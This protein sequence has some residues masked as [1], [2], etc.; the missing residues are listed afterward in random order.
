MENNLELSQKV[1][2]FAASEN[3][4]DY[5]GRIPRGVR[6]YRYCPIYR[7]PSFSDSSLFLSVLHHEVP[8]VRLAKGVLS[9]NRNDAHSLHYQYLYGIGIPLKIATNV[10][11][12]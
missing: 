10:F 3:Y 5:P 1:P 9:D 4:S 6:L 2:I 12:W 7:E 8:D 11:C